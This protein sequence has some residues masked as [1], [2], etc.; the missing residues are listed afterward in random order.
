MRV[1]T[2]I[3]EVRSQTGKAALA[4]VTTIQGLRL[5]VHSIQCCDGLHQ[6]FIFNL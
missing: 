4:V 5:A 6:V 1:K 2:Q 3:A